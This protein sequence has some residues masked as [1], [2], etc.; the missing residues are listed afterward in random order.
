MKLHCG[1]TAADIHLSSVFGELLRREMYSEEKIIL[2]IQ[3]GGFV[4]RTAKDGAF[5]HSR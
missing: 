5:S 2:Y 1:V 3:G 4:G